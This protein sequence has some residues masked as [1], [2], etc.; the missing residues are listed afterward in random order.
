[1]I[2][3]QIKMLK[4]GAIMAVVLTIGGVLVGLFYNGVTSAGDKIADFKVKKVIEDTVWV[5]DDGE[6]ITFGDADEPGGYCGEGTYSVGSKDNVKII[7][8]GASYEDVFGMKIEEDDYL[9]TLSIKDDDS[10]P[11][12]TLL[13]GNDMYIDSKEIKHY[14]KEGS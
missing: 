10:S 8:F 5:S 14:T 11:Y 3:Y 7:G 12:L 6:K 4:Y 2:E 9:F 13:K 1:M